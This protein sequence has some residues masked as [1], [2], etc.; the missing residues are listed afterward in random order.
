MNR[1]D[2]IAKATINPNWDI[3]II[4]GGATGLGAAIDAASRGYKCLLIEQYDFAKGTSSK[5]TKLL[6][7]GVRY[8]QQGNISLVMEALRERGRLLKNAPHLSSIQSFI[9][10]VYSCWEKW[11]YAIGL[12][13]YD[14]MAGS[15]SIGSTKILS[16][17][18]IIEALPAINTTQL[19]GG[20]LY[21]D[22]Q[23]DDSSMC[24]E[25]AATAIKHGATIINYCKAVSFI[26]TNQKITGLH[27][28]DETTKETFEVKTKVVVNATGVFTN[29]IMQLDDKH[30][31]DY[32]TPS[33]GIHLMI[34]P[35]FFAGE[36]AMMI[37]KTSDG[38]VLFA[39]P[40]HGKIIIGT[41]DTVIDKIAIEPKP[42]EEE[43]NFIITH[44]NKYCLTSISR[45]D[46]LSVYVGLRPLIKH[47]GIQSA[48][49]SRAHSLTVSNSGLITITG[50]KWTTYRQMAEDAI[51]NAIFVGKLKK[52]ICIT[53]NLPIGDPNLKENMIKHIIL[54]NPDWNQPIHPNF[55]FK[56]AEIIY[57][58]RY[59]M[60]IHLEDVLARRVR[61]LY[62]DARMAI[63]VAPEVARIMAKEMQK[64]TE[65]TMNEINSF[66]A[67]ANQ[68]IV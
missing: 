31:H 47:S 18:K 26:K 45:K 66:T 53:K 16:K 52:S 50:G 33:Q 17:K 63:Q 14:L 61:L 59:Q 34:E 9:I 7:G 4:G 29:A 55:I 13:L 12:K 5:S 49:L 1:K 64:D 60:A 21:Y 46:I 44:F 57:A 65:W 48:Q 6:H 30:L 51:D 2:Q 11:F 23:F 8:L 3:V 25:M 39:V 24:I 27:I 15:Y 10:P 32:V 28:V 58:I 56:K 41:T 54:E 35:C 36:N 42:L 37:P 19:V 38:R 22:G 68:Y 67:L 40:W 62:L 43:I 20:V